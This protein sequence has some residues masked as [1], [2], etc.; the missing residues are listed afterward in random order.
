MD[1]KAELKVYCR[2]PY[3]GNGLLFST[4]ANF[5]NRLRKTL[6][7]TWFLQK[8]LEKLSDFDIGM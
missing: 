5:R 6:I 7:G 8:L 3:L 2:S 1:A 4:F